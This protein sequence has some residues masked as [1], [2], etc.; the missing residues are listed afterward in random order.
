M[1][2]KVK[3]KT[4]EGPFDLL[5]YLIESARMDIYDIKVSEIT[6]QYMEHLQRMQ[7]LDVQPAALVALADLLLQPGE[8]LPLYGPG[9]IG[10]HRVAAL[11]GFLNGHGS[12]SRS[13]FL[14]GYPHHDHT[15]SARKRQADRTVF[16]CG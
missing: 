3:L 2:Y 12:S 5:V 16:A 6:E 9:E 14:R 7:E 11:H 13:P 1:G 4:F 8:G 10:A 15:T